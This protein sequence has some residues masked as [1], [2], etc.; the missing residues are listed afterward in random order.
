MTAPREPGLRLRR[1]SR[2]CES[3]QSSIRLREHHAPRR[4]LAR[5]HALARLL[6]AVERDAAD[7]RLGLGGDA[8][9]RLARAVPVRQQE[10]ARL[11]DL[12]LE[13]VVGVRPRSVLASRN[14]LARSNRSVCIALQ[15]RAD[16]R[17]R[18]RPAARPSPSPPCRAGRGGPARTPSSP[19]PSAPARRGPARRCSSHSLN[20][21]PGW[22]WSRSSTLTVSGS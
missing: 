14:C 22:Y 11:L 20:L 18:P 19:G 10:A 1:R 7:R 17:R 4:R 8:V 13:L 2:S 21:K 9:L 6:R 3:R 5:H 12:L 15:Q 16:A